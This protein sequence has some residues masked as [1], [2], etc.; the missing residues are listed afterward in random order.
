MTVICLHHLEATGRGFLIRRSGTWREGWFSK[1]SS[2]HEGVLTWS[3]FLLV[4]VVDTH[5]FN[6]GG[7]YPLDLSPFHPQSPRCLTLKLPLRRAKVGL[8]TP[9]WEEQM[10]SEHRLAKVLG[11]RTTNGIRSHGQWLPRQIHPISSPSTCL[12]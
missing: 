4:A 1:R 12:T 8:G 9:N 5:T 2:D 11:W 7:A 6:S 10:D 3:V